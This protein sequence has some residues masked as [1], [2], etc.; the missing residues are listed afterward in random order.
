MGDS[1]SLDSERTE[2]AMAEATNEKQDLLQ[3]GDSVIGGS[4]TA[5][6]RKGTAHENNRGLSSASTSKKES[7]GRGWFGDTK[8]LT[9]VDGNDLRMGYF[10]R[11]SPPLVAPTLAANAHKE[12]VS[13]HSE[14]I[15]R[16]VGPQQEG[17]QS[18][19]DEQCGDGQDTMA[20]LLLYQ[21]YLQALNRIATRRLKAAHEKAVNMVQQSH[22]RSSDERTAGQAN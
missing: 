16:G 1:S 11:Q 19:P 3:L 9:D 17:R 5:P 2:S 12:N 15:K 4:F 6:N 20:D 18:I 7:G 22:L 14:I 10:S 13:F 8:C 21:S